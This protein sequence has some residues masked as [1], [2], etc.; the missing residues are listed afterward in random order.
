[1]TPWES[2]SLP[3]IFIHIPIGQISFPLSKEER[4]KVIELILMFMRETVLK[5]ALGEHLVELPFI[6]LGKHF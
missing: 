1:M 5:A 6:L 4:F 2:M 3:C